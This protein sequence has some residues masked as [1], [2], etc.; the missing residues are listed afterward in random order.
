MQVHKEALLS[1]RGFW[2]GLLHHN[3]SFDVL[4]KAVR[5]MDVNIRQAERVYRWVGR[6][7]CSLETVAWVVSAPRRHMGR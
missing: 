3:V 6:H 5:R 1:M 4:T 7:V 2:G